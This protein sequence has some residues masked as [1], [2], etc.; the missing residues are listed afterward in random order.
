MS[1]EVTVPVEAEGFTRQRRSESLPFGLKPTTQKSVTEI[2]VNDIAPRIFHVTKKMDGEPCT[3]AIRCSVRQEDVGDVFDVIPVEIADA[4]GNFNGSFANFYAD[5]HV[6][7]RSVDL[8]VKLSEGE[9]PDNIYTKTMLPL[10]PEFFRIIAETGNQF[11]EDEDVIFVFRGE[12]CG[13]GIKPSKVNK[14]A[15]GEPTFHLTESYVLKGD[16]SEMLTFHNDIYDH[17]DDKGTT[18]APFN[19][20]ERI[21]TILLTKEN[22]DEVANKYLNAPASDG[23]GVVLWE[24]SIVFGHGVLTGFSFKIGSKEY[25]EAQS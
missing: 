11:V 14:D 9:E 12:I 25:L 23:E 1:Q 3:V 13:Q 10:W 5:L 8:K 7:S 2:E 20:C 6:C 22:V 18:F 19:P 17:D 4:D 16:A 21:A 15:V 24:K